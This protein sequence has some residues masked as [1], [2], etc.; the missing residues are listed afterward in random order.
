MPKEDIFGYHDELDSR[1]E[2]WCKQEEVY[3]FCDKET[4]D[5]DVAFAQCIYE[6]LMMYKEVANEAIDLT[7]HKFEYNGK[8]YTQLEL[9]NILIEDCKMVIIG[10]DIDIEY[11]K[12]MEEVYDILKLCH[13]TLWW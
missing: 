13:H 6:R 10:S 4:W 12:I 11:M 9:I 5:L 1:H 3:G 2:R 8:K 7:F